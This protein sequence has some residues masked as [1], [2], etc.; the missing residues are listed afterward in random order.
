M[1]TAFTL[2]APRPQRAVGEPFHQWSFPDGS[3]W[4]RFHRAGGDYMVRF[5]DLADFT[6]SA[7]AADV[8]CVP[9]PAVSGETCRHLYLNQVLPLALSRRGNMVFHASAVELA[10][11]ALAFVAE[12]GRGKSTLAASFATAGCRFLADDGLV[13]RPA[14]AGY[15]A[16]PSHPSIRLWEDS[17]AALIADPAR[18]APPVQYTSKGRFLADGAMA[19]CPE[20]R[21]LGAAF[22]LGPGSAVIEIERLAGAQ[23]LVEWVRN[24]FMLDPREDAALAAQF[25]QLAALANRL[26]CFRLDYPRSFGALAEV[27]AAIAACRGA[28]A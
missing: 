10:G 8:R 9:A 25:E 24:S 14:A 12:S 28:L 21:P 23:A 7:D 20:V 3:P 19:F 27:R 6:I 2:L 1:V 5:P 17:E 11:T 18:A 13:V 16:L 4:A 26:P 15:E 22:F